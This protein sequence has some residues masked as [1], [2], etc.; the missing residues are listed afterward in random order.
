VA[1][2]G[3][4]LTGG[5]STRMGQDKALLVIDGSEMTSIVA[6][7]LRDAGARE[8]LTVGGDLCALAMLSG[9]DRSVPDAD[10][11]EG[12]LGGILTAMRCSV[13]DVVVV[14]A[15]DT[16]AI[17]SAT[18]VALVA[19]LL[20]DPAA[21]VAYAEVDGRVQPLTAAWRI[22]RSWD[23]VSEAFAAGE[24]AP[25]TVFMSLPAIAVTN[26][27]ASAVDDVDRPSD[28]RRYAAEPLTSSTPNEDSR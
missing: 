16:P 7:A 19:A 10:P 14:L 22:S 3:A 23:L 8:V 15:C 4:V 1:F 20:S 11:G 17:T 6:T 13:D 21:G 26:V 9:V 2:T 27:L 28:L 18:P 25:R 24:R 12:P 5:A